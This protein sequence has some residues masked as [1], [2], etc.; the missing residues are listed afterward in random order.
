VNPAGELSRMWR[1]ELRE[2]VRA[3]DEEWALGPLSIEDRVAKLEQLT[4]L[5]VW[6]LGRLANEQPSDG[7]VHHRADRGDD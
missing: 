1:E 5:V 4:V 3:H 2:R 7:H 6:V